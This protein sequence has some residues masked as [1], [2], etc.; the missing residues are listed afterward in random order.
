MANGFYQIKKGLNIGQAGSDPS[1]GAEG[2]VYNNT[3]SL[4]LRTF[5]NGNW[6]EIISN[7]DSQ[8]LSNKT[9]SPNSNAL[10]LTSAQ[11]LVGN[12]SNIGSDVA[13]S[14][15]LS[16]ANTGAFT[17]QKIQTN[18][19]SGTTGTG[20]VVFSASPTVSGTLT[21]A[22]STWSG[23]MTI[24]STTTPKLQLGTRTHG[25]GDNLTGNIL[26][27]DSASGVSY[28]TSGNSDSSNNHVYWGAASSIQTWGI[29]SDAGSTTEYLRLDA[30]GNLGIGKSP[31]SLLDVNGTAT[32]GDVQGNGTNGYII[33][34]SGGLAALPTGLDSSC[35]IGRTSGAGSA[36]FDQA[37]SMIFRSRLSA[38]SGQGSM[39]FYTGSTPNLALKLDESGNTTT[40][41]I[42]SSI[43]SGSAYNGFTI[44]NTSSTG[45]ARTVYLIGASGANGEA[46]V[47]Y[48]PG[49][50][51]K[52]SVE[53]N[54]T[55]TPIK[56]FTNNDTLALTI[57][58]AQKGI[59][60]KAF[61]VKGLTTAG[62]TITDTSGNISSEAHLAISRGGTGAATKAA[63]FDALSPMNASGDIVYGGASGTGTR[64]AKGSNGQVLTLVSGVPAWGSGIT[65][66]VP[67]I[68]KFT[69]GTGT[70][71]TPAGVLY[72]RVRMVGGGGGGAGSGTSSGT[73]AGAGGNTTFGTTLLAANGGAL[74]NYNSD[75]GAGG[76]A[77]LGS[78]PIGVA[79]SGGGGGNSGNQITVNGVSGGSPGGNSIFGGG[80]PGGSYGSAG[81]N[82]STNSGGGGGGGGTNNTVGSSW[83][84]GGGSGGSVDAII[85]SPSSTYA[86]A[87]GSGGTGGGAGPSGLAGGNG[88][89]GIIIVE[90]HYQ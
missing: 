27:L 38:T 42:T 87:V 20:N 82:A 22:T 71:T 86:Y 77:S 1:G 44:A 10:S 13:V 45:F 24:T 76:S 32:F 5:I 33:G 35:V 17:V 41:V 79:I 12:S 8:T 85:T 37:G 52:M 59:F 29:V 15:D 53:A 2:D 47:S 61:Q 80:A 26:E 88:A 7:S 6:R 70:Y 72:I 49:T 36:P 66:V 90:E 60:E 56:F 43:S 25:P 62:P 39:Y 21:G 50:F 58:S 68:Q 65:P 48:A 74:C 63:G 4:K 83:G 89:A 19:V 34:P 57:D 51:F 81:L 30:S 11:I 54:D 9:I 3:T 64:L 18:T 84:G 69:S 14:G 40:G 78:G 31:G 55:S 46:A 67:T 73:S 28:I 16:L 23:A 75:G